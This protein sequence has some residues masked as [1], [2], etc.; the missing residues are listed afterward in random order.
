MLTS[1]PILV[2]TL[3]LPQST[4]STP[5]GFQGQTNNGVPTCAPSLDDA[6]SPGNCVL[7]S[8]VPQ[9]G[10]LYPLTSNLFVDVGTGWVGLGTT[11]PEARLDVIGDTHHEGDVY[12]DDDIDGIQFS[13]EDGNVCAGPTPM[14][15]MF[16]DGANNPDR[17]VI[18]HSPG[19]PTW[20]L[21]Y[22]DA[23]DRFVF[24]RSGTPVMTV[25]LQASEVVVNDG[26][27]LIAEDNLIVQ[28]VGSF[29]DQCFFNQFISVFTND[30]IFPTMENTSQNAAQFA[31]T[32]IGRSVAPNF[33]NVNLLVQAPAA[34]GFSNYNHIE[35]RNITNF[36]SE[37]R[38]DA[39]GNVYADGSHTGP[40]DFAEMIQVT[41]GAQSVEPGDLLVIDPA[42][43]RGVRLS[44]SPRSRLVAG[45]YSTAP[46]FVGSERDWDV[47]EGVV[48]D[49]GGS[50][51]QAEIRSLDR[52]DMAEL[53]DEVPVA[54]VGIVPVKATTENGPIRPGDLL[55]S[56][57]ILGHVM[58]DEDPRLGT[59]V[60]KALESLDAGEGL[61]R[62]LVTLQ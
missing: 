54:I 10:M 50:Q 57:S 61:I 42:A 23:A 13:S 26:N 18:A 12:F 33:G 19:F 29:I 60:G 2:F 46:G 11:A 5:L 3:A 32:V 52:K 34:T 22:E 49:P 45:I 14:I 37:F 1:L 44:S 36:D 59:V 41:T 20:G 40:A 4:T 8:S 43:P 39:F 53:Y 35:A 27:T 25:D 48:V 56:S 16:E 55:V 47:L 28:G 58:R 15:S 30:P 21:G 6:G 51:P 7:A 24:Q 17:M 62:I 9:L 38:V 31:T